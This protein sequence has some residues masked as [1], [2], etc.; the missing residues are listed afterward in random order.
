M[1]LVSGKESFPAIDRRF[2]LATATEN[3]APA[4]KRMRCVRSLKPM[5]ADLR[6]G[7]T[8]QNLHAKKFEYKFARFAQRRRAESAEGPIVLQTGLRAVDGNGRMAR[9]GNVK[10]Q[11]I[12]DSFGSDSFSKEVAPAFGFHFV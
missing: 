7:H 8:L 1:Y 9:P 4:L 2:F 12:L 11:G 5:V 3:P 6:L 10:L